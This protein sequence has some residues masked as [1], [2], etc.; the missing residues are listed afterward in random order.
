MQSQTTAGTVPV[1]HQIADS[2]RARI[3]SEDLKAGDPLPSVSELTQLWACSPG[4]A[5]SALDVLRGEGRITGGRGKPATV[6]V[7]PRRVRL[8]IDWTQEQK[9]L[10]LRPTEERKVR[11]AIEMT[12]GIPIEQLD[13]SHRYSQ[14]P[15]SEDLAAEFQIEPG[16]TLVR[17][18]YEMTDKA[19]GHR[20]TWS[21]SHIPLTLIEGNPDLLDEDKEPWP[22]GHQHQLYT[23]GI[24]L[25]RFE[26]SVIAIQPTTAD[27]QVWGME[28]GVPLLQVRS[29]SIDI[30][31]RVV[32]ISDATYPADRTE[33]HFTE[34]LT[35]WPANYPRYER[36]EDQ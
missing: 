14:V 3:E 9:D 25:G 13:S 18:A 35:R 23:V 21:V 16:A 34:H 19:T 26:R 5:R 24:E 32:E 10:V 31:D 28:P 29:R 27:R 33:I 11:G 22:G 30:D 17:R 36:D 1:H 8:T 6:R 12:A 7:P 15:A 4:V 2:L 20:V